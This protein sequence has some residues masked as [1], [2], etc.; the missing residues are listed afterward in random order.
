MLESQ[1]SAEITRL[2]VAVVV[3]VVVLV[4]AV[5]VVVVV[6][7]QSVVA[8]LVAVQVD[9]SDVEKIVAG[10]SLAPSDSW[11]SDIGD[12]FGNASEPTG[13]YKGYACVR[14]HHAGNHSTERCGNTRIATRRVQNATPG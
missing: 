7:V 3:S 4:V 12:S 10:D 5:V 8:V 9:T 14:I 11:L 6:V 2:V 13:S 1:D